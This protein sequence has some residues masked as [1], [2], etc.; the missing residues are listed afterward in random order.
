[1]KKL[2]FLS[3]I[4]VVFAFSCNAQSKDSK[5]VDLNE[6]TFIEKVADYK[7]LNNDGFKYVGKKPAIVDFYAAWCGPCKVIAPILDELS[8]KYSGSVDFY[9]VDIDKVKSLSTA[10]GITSIPVLLFIPLDGEPQMIKGAR[11]KDDYIKF[12][13]DLLLKKE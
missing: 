4:M 10:F 5:V 2:M 8:V 9:K 6:A 3:L 12:I 1:M 7:T 13:D 11:S